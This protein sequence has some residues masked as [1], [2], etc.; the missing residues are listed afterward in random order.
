MKR[1]EKGHLQFLSRPHRKWGAKRRARSD[2]RSLKGADEE[3]RCQTVTS[4]L[5]RSAR[6]ARRT[7]LGYG[8]LS[9]G[10]AVGARAA[11]RQAASR[12]QSQTKAAPFDLS[13]WI[14]RP[15]QGFAPLVIPGVVTRAEAKGDFGSMMQPNYL[16]PKPEV[17]RRLLERA[18]TDLTGAPNLQESLA[19]FIHED[20]VVAIKVNGIA[21]QTGY[22]MA[23]NYEVILPV[24]E[25]LMGLGV[26]PKNITIY[27]QFPAH[28]AGTRVGV[29]KWTLP[30]GVQTG[31]HNNE[32]CEMPRI[33]VFEDIKT[34]YCT[35]LTD[36]TAV[37]DMTQMK[38]HHLCGFTGAMKNI[39]HGSIE[40]PED[41]HAHRA[42]PQIAMLYNHPIVQSR[43]RLHIVD[44]FKIIYDKGPLD[45]DPDMRV[46]H[47]AIYA[48]TDAVAMDTVG[49]KVIEDERKRRGGMTLKAAGREP[50]YIRR[51]AELGIGVHDWNQ[52]RLHSVVI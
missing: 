7:V 38:E 9:L 23:V 51:A 11:P 6:L 35:L 34:R 19:R 31:T 40:N 15:P 1:A 16:W 18:L 8:V 12:K 2:D 25:G 46:P 4:P 26:R 22:T 33:A 39:T 29:G 41:H 28:L 5:R 48:S 30:E 13:K 3:F 27:E 32:K 47:G 50:R 14:A 36:A 43:V 44:A 49:W 37:I 17:A 45:K 21:G 42:S 52:L 20:D 10:A 24:V